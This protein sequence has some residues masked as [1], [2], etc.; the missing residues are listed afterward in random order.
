MK[1][2][3]ISLVISTAGMVYALPKDNTAVQWDNVALQ[4]VRDSKLGAPIVA[5]ALAIVHTCMYDAWAAYD[6]RAIGTQLSGALR[7]PK[8]E[9]TLEN[10]DKA[11]SYASYRALI[12]VLPSDTE[13]LYKPLMKRLGYDWKD[14]STDIETP[15]GIGNVACGAVLEFRH[16]DKSNQ[17][18]DLSQGAYSDWTHYRPVNMPIP[19]P[20]KLPVIHPVD[21]NHWQP[22]IFVNSTGDF[23]TQMFSGAQWCDVTPFAL[24]KGDEFRSIAEKLGPATYGSDEYQQQAEE[25]VQINANLTDR[26]KM[27]SEYWSDEPDSEQLLGHWMMFA[28]WVSA[29]DHHTFDD[30]VEMFFALSNAILDSSIAAWDM[31]RAFDSVRPATAIPFLLSGKKIRAW[32]GPGKGTVDMD[33]SQWIPYQAATFPTPPFPDYVSG[34]STYS[35]AAATILAAWTKSDRFGYSVTVPTGSSKIEPG[36]TPKRLVTL[37]WGT[38]SDAAD[39]A[40]MS[41]RYGGIHFRRA[42][43]AGRQL[44]RLVGQKAWDR[45]QRY[46]DGTAKP[47]VLEQMAAQN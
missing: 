11:I 23:A 41:R 21:M 47:L 8:S 7:R 27:I 26:E 38:F 10:K 20:V 2:F 19:F 40:G 5:R 12:D 31:K 43:L 37:Q 1:H 28:Q 36:I 30:D 34:Q 16:H 33:G 42:D 45:A 18:G 4:G 44:G 39:E 35:A 46:F 14:D 22:L 3:W 6:E 25:L 13:S 29:R 17:L 32:G 15:T 9:Q 24:A